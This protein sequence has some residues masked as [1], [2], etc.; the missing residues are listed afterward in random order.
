M[1]A[2]VPCHI[3]QHAPRILAIA[4]CDGFGLLINKSRVLKSTS[5][6]ADAVISQETNFANSRNALDGCVVL[7]GAEETCSPLTLWQFGTSTLHKVASS[8]A[9]TSSVA[10]EISMLLAASH[11][12]GVGGHIGQRFEDCTLPRTEMTIWGGHSYGKKPMKS[13]KNIKMNRPC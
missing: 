9:Q 2:C 12:L 6:R 5:L 11:S 3:E 13:E 7:R 4:C 10:L 8:T 1:Y